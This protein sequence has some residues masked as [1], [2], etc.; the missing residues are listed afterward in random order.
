[1][2]F[3]VIGNDLTVTMAAEGGQLQLNVFEPVIAFNIF[4]S[5]DM[6]IQA[7]IVF[8]ERTVVGIEA[9]R[10]RIRQ[11]LERSIGIVT[12]LVPYIGYER[13]SAVAR[14]ALESHR[15]VYEL[16]LDKEWMTREELDRILSPDAMT[17]PR[18]MPGR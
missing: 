8:R 2:A 16:V 3:Q 12:A 14:E 13:A 11:G 10:D 4:Q 6:L 1:V 15:G 18:G 5:V 17:R 9:D 7:C